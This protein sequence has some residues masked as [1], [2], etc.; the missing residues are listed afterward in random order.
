MNFKASDS[1]HEINSQNP[2]NLGPFTGP[3]SWPCTYILAQCKEDAAGNKQAK[4]KQ[5][6]FFVIIS[7]AT[8]S[9]LYLTVT[10]KII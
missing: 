5:S 4:Y 10:L 1:E 6:N 9:I 3:Q 2:L 8:F 7:L